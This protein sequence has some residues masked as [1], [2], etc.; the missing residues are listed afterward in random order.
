MNSPKSR[1]GVEEGTG[2]R[3]LSPAVSAT[4]KLPGQPV[5]QGKQGVISSRWSSG[6]VPAVSLSYLESRSEAPYCVRWILRNSDG[7]FAL[8]EKPAISW[9]PELQHAPQTVVKMV[10]MN[11]VVT[12]TADE[13]V[14]AVSALKA[15]IIGRKEL[16]PAQWKRA[17]AQDVIA[18]LGEVT[19]YKRAHAHPT[20][21]AQGGF[22]DNSTGRGESTSG[23]GTSE[24]ET[25]D[26]A[27]G[28]RGAYSISKDAMPDYLKDAVPDQPHDTTSAHPHNT[29]KSRAYFGELKQRRSADYAA[30]EENALADGCEK[31]KRSKL[32][33]SD[34]LDT[35]IDNAKEVM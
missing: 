9:D 21:D 19:E 16:P 2:C 31:A 22:A 17:F 18:V 7:D 20:S 34:T 26:T 1:S 3:P 35:Y 23:G 29:M 8:L 11:T 15:E 25:A 12:L 10:D 30:F 5:P 14:R 28:S 13:F 24:S 6:G 4:L 27:P 33:D 32:A